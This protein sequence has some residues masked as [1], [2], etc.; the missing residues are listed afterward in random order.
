MKINGIIEFSKIWVKDIAMVLA[1]ISI[2]EIILPN[3]NM[4]KYI[5]MIIGILVIVVIITP[6]TKLI[7]KDV[8]LD[9]H[10]NLNQTDQA[11]FH[12]RAYPIYRGIV[13]IYIL[14][15]GRSTL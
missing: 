12:I 5:D 14:V 11:G 2:V 7:N 9:T 3:S 6:F 10:I 13:I 8:H 15:L 1:I 4:K